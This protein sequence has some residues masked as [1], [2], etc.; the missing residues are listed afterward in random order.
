MSENR[1]ESYLPRASR[2]REGLSGKSMGRPSG[3]G[4]GGLAG[5]CKDTSGQLQG[6]SV[7]GL[8]ECQESGAQPHTSSLAGEDDRS[9]QEIRPATDSTSTS[10]W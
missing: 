2:R 10:T 8:E 9:M 5:S 3:H 1:V 4:L 7:F 6:S